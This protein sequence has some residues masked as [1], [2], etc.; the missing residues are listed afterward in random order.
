MGK[1]DTEIWKMYLNFFLMTYLKVVLW[2]Q[3]TRQNEEPGNQQ[4]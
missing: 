2:L 3:M 1:T 4:Q